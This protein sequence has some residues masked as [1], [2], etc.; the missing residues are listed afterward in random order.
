MKAVLGI[1]VLLGAAGAIFVA[2]W[3]QLLL[4]HATYAV[5]FSKTGGLDRRVIA[6]GTF[7]WRWERVIPNNVTLF[8]FEVQPY[9]V[10]TQVSGELPAADAVAGMLPGSA[11]FHYQ[12]TVAVTFSVRP[13]ALPQLVADTGLTPERLPQWTGTQ[14]A[15]VARAALVLLQRRGAAAALLDSGAT[16][17]ELLERLAAGFPHLQITGIRFTDL[18]LPD[19]EIYQRGRQAYLALMDAQYE[20]RRAAAIDLA[21]EFERE[22]AAQETR[23]AAAQVLRE[24]GALLQEYP[25]LIQFLALQ[26]D[27]GRD[28]FLELPEP[29]AAPQEP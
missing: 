27:A 21:G 3:I 15:D 9:S 23:R 16:E 22:R 20:A 2:G 6:A 24:Y 8:V 7:V 1:L 18:R 4:P 17:A 5:L 28:A 10:E 29:L 26:S 14:G 12:A 25:I 13:D 11:D 19:L